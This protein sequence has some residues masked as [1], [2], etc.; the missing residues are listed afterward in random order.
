MHTMPGPA[1]N[2]YVMPHIPK[3]DIQKS[4][5]EFR[6]LTDWGEPLAGAAY[7]AILSD[8]SIRKGTLDAQGRA[9]ITGLRAGTTAKV[10]Y[11]YKP[12]QASSTVDTEMHE[13]VHEFLNWEPSNAES[14][15]NA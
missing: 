6:H 9:R 1:T 13:D 12:L 7:K 2:P 10:E 8:G 14:G 4:D 11:N 3:T 5:L 15:N